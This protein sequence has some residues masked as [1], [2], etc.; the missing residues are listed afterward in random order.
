MLENNEK[1]IPGTFSSEGETRL[2]SAELRN[3]P[4]EKEG[5]SFIS[6]S[7]RGKRLFEKLPVQEIQYR[8]DDNLQRTA[9]V[10]QKSLIHD[11][12]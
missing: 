5:Y 6:I 3:T 2:E 9:P 10:S 8:E 7:A 11:V 4:S 12:Y 1:S